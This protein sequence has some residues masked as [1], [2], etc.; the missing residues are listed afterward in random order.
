MNIF[1]LIAFFTLIA[2]AVA[3]PQSGRFQKTPKL[4]VSLSK[5]TLARTCYIKNVLAEVNDYLELAPKLSKVVTFFREG[6]QDDVDT[7]G[8]MGYRKVSTQHF[9]YQFFTVTTSQLKIP[10]LYSNN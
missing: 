4:Q 1:A 2:A 6:G 5:S 7:T 9:I 8:S 3:N 10:Y